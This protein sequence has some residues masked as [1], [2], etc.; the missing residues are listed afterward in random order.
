M[1][2]AEQ[3][4]TSITTQSLSSTLKNTS[5]IILSTALVNI[6]DVTGVYHSCRVV[7]DSGSQSNFISEQCCDKLKLPKKSVDIPISGIG[8]TLSYIR[9][10][11][12]TTI[13]SR[14]DAFTLSLNCLIIP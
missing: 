14:M 5:Q 12:R 13:K 8:E 1:L 11:T 3:S 6:A 10:S 2:H 7:L 9:Y 4:T